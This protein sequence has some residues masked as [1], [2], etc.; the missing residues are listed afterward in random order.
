MS[1]KRLVLKNFQSHKESALDFS[2][3]VNVIVGDS[4]CGKSAIL[5]ALYWLTFCRPSG[6]SFIRRGIKTPC[7]VTLET[8]DGYKIKRIKGKGENYY[9]LNGEQFKA[10]AKSVPDDVA[11]ALNL[12]E[13]NFSRQ[14]DGPFG[15][16]MSGTELAQYLN[17]LVDLNIIG[18]SLSNIN[19]MVRDTTAIVNNT[20]QKLERTKS[21]I[22]KLEWVHEAEKDVAKLE[23]LESKVQ[24]ECRRRDKLV[25][26][27]EWY[28][29]AKSKFDEISYYSKLETEYKKI[30]IK[31]Q[32]LSNDMEA[33]ELAH[34][35]LV[36]YKNAKS[37]VTNTTWIK[38]AE[39]AILALHK[40]WQDLNIIK[41]DYTDIQNLLSKY[42]AAKDNVSRIARQCK[43]AMEQFNR[44]KPHTCP[45]CGQ[46]WR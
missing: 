39:K 5:R 35:L 18:T 16:S 33:A 13:I 23:A 36:S 3:G 41:R 24:R 7:C 28:K 43:E 42:K 32:A 34:K 38:D 29:E 11:K 17:K 14:L 12:G 4:D 21:E 37:K 19:S 27:L 6:D 30:N 25:K 22:K 31:T 9:E 20:K 26:E 10:F 8:N 44:N 15:F 2:E 1:I 46:E 45:L 40:R